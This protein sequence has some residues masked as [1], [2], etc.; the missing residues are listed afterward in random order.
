M[1]VKL[2]INGKEF[3]IEAEV[4]FNKGCKG[5]NI[6]APTIDSYSLTGEFTFN[7]LDYSETIIEL[8]ELTDGHLYDNLHNQINEG[9]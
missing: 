1:K 7:G 4:E 2:E 3:E 8:N 6:T 5:D 9:V